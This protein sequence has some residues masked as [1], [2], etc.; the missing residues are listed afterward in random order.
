ME[1][2]TNTKKGKD[3]GTAEAKDGKT[4]K[5]AVSPA[6]LTEDARPQPDEPMFLRRRS[7]HVFQLCR[8]RWGTTPTF[9]DP[10]QLIAE[11]EAYLDWTDET[12]V[13][14]Y[15]PVKSGNLAGTIIPVPRKHLRTETEFCLFLGASPGFL[16]EKRLQYWQN[17]EEFGLEA[18][19]AFVNAI[20]AIRKFIAD[21]MDRGAAATLYD[22]SYIRA[23]RGHK[24]ILDYTSG[25]EP[26]KGGITIQVTD[27]R[28]ASR[29]AK[30]K[31][32]KKGHDRSGEG[33]E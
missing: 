27:P 21:D 13:Y 28:T 33:K 10:E 29:V 4:K 3:E 30:L 8:R 16:G 31:E 26:V 22:P 9:T 25:G 18:C 5:K 2:K 11:F 20:D 6:P 17:Y 19:L 1:K 23:M 32:F 14:S 7:D 24:T 15:E 12:P